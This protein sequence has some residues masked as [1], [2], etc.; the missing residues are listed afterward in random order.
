MAS[1]TSA[2][3]EQYLLLIKVGL[4][5]SCRVVLVSPLDLHLLRRDLANSNWIPSHST[6]SNR[7]DIFLG[8]SSRDRARKVLVL[9]S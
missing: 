4:L 7:I 8:D 9:P 1:S 2:K 5:T 3:L 6:I